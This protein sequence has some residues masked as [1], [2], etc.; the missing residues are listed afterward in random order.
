[1]LAL[2]SIVAGLKYRTRLDK[3]LPSLDF[4]R[5]RGCIAISC[6]A[7]YIFIF[8]AGANFN[9]RLIFLLGVLGYLVEDIEETGTSRSLPAAVAIVFFCLIPFRL[10][11]LREVM[12][13]LIFCAACAWLS[14]QVFDRIQARSDLPAFLPAS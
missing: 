8:L 2:L 3:F 9:Y 14:T 6:L 12:D 5:A 13:G 7:I 11:L 1:M 4:C 10:V